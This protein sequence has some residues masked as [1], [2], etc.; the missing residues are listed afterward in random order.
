ME[1]LLARMRTAVNGR[2]DRGIPQPFSVDY[3]IMSRTVLEDQASGNLQ[4]FS[5]LCV[6]SGSGQH[7]LALKEKA[8]HIGSFVFEYDQ[9]YLDFLELFFSSVANHSTASSKSAHS[10]ELFPLNITHGQLNTTTSS[11]HHVSVLSQPFSPRE[12]SEDLQALVTYFYE[13]S[14]RND[15]RTLDTSHD[16]EQK[17]DT[18]HPPMR[19]ELSLSF[20]MYCLRLE[21]EKHE[22]RFNGH[23]T[24]PSSQE[25]VTK[26]TNE[27]TITT[28]TDETIST[29]SAATAAPEENS[30][31]TTVTSAPDSVNIT[32]TGELS[33]TTITPLPDEACVSSSETT[34]P[35]DTDSTILSD[36]TLHAEDLGTSDGAKNL[37]LHPL[38][39][40]HLPNDVTLP[41]EKV[42]PSLQEFVIS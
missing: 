22:Q 15:S 13:W 40:L 27:G 4:T 24:S 30:S 37:S 16:R 25:I 7:E 29:M 11:Y 17:N 19:I 38:P 34:V 5:P 28:V 21:E 6:M 31:L 35:A 33:M 3:Q 20:L 1:Q 9:H 10:L 18:G 41:Q 12:N 39:L 32:V 26:D 14:Q 2:N 36:S 23:P 8:L 42:V